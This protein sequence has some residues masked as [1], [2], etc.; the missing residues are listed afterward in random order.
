MCV[1]IID[2]GAPQSSTVYLDRAVT[3]FTEAASRG[4]VDVAT[5]ARAG[6]AAT[7]AQ[8]GQWSE[9][10]SQAAQVPDGFSYVMPYYATEGDDQRNRIQWA[11]AAEPYKAHSQWNTWVAGY[12]LS[13][14]N[15]DGDPR[16][17]Y[18]LTDE[19][20][21][22]AIDCCGQVPWWP[23]NKY[24]DS[25]GDIELSSGPEMRLLEAEK[26]MMDGSVD[27]AMAKVNALRAAA[28]MDAVNPGSQFQAWEF[29][30]REHAIEMWLEGRRLGAL[31]RWN[32][33]GLSEDDLHPLEQ[34]SG[35]T[36][37]G[38]HLSTRTC[39]FPVPESECDTNLSAPC[40]G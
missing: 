14:D 15:P 31:R 25:G 2:G 24:P 11:S 16:V 26:A 38:S 12:G 21:D 13:S 35:D 9:A 5:A 36:N 34:V 20:G 4:S 22:A 17:P 7:Y 10:L 37:V 8:L 28:G 39:C 33:A 30:K 3:N 27:G 23:Q 40:P 1:G 19:T 29:F 18:T 32:D 6:L